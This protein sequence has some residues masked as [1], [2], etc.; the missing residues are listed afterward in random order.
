[1][2]ILLMSNFSGVCLPIAV[3]GPGAGDIGKDNAAQVEVIPKLESKRVTIPETHLEETSVVN[4]NGAHVPNYLDLGDAY[5]LAVGTIRRQLSEKILEQKSLKDSTKISEDLKV[6]LSQMSTARGLELPSNDISPRVF[7]NSDDVKTSDSSILMGMHLL[8]RRI[9]LER[10]ESGLSLDGS[11]ISE[12]EGESMVDRLKRQVEHDRKLMGTLYKELEEER[13]AS[14]IATN[15]AMAMI[16][17]LQEEKSALHMEALQCLRMMEE[18]AEYDV[19][20]V[21][22]ANDLLVEKEKVIQDLEAELESYRMKMGNVLAVDT[23]PISDLRGGDMG[24]E[25]SDSNCT[26]HRSSISCF[27]NSDRHVTSSKTGTSDSLKSSLIE[28][29]D[30]RMYIL[31]RLQTLERELDLFTEKGVHMDIDNVDNLV[32][33]EN[34]GSEQH[35][36]DNVNEQLVSMVSEDTDLVALKREFF[37]L[38]ERLEVLAADQNF[39]EHSINSLRHGNDG[40]EFIQDIVFQLRQLNRIGVGRTDY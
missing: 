27:S 22:K 23:A 4:D 28:F 13:S 5:K 17:R 10:N 8:Q 34:K 16:T 18:Q 14:A 38:R 40:L 37:E 32:M 24:A 1:M 2:T 21:Q 33:H 35:D 36:N 7:G 12:I 25:H 39:L 19:E 31:Q 11:I 29:E 15:E 9:S 6:L 30:E 3:N 26:K 20:A